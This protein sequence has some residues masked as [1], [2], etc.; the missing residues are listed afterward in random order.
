MDTLESNKLIAEFVGFVPSGFDR[1][2]LFNSETR[3]HILPKDLKYSKSWDWLM[4][5]VEKIMFLELEDEDLDEKL[6]EFQ[7]KIWNEVTNFNVKACSLEIG[8]FLEW[9]NENK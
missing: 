3:E 9:Y 1:S 7:Y 5:A 8:N 4:P 2:M 6:E